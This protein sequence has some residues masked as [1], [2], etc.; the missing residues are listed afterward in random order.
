MFDIVAASDIYITRIGAN[1]YAGTTADYEIYYK[2]GSYVGFE[3]NASAWTKVG[4]TVSVYSFTNN[5]E[6][7]IPIDIN[8]FVAAGEHYA[9]YVTNT[10]SGGLNYTVSATGNVTL[11]TN[12]D[13]TMTGGV[14]KAY[15]FSST[16]SYR[17]FNGTI[18]YTKGSFISQ[19]SGLGSGA[20]FPVGVT[21]ESY[22]ASDGL[23]NTTNCSFTVTVKGLP[24]LTTSA[25]SSI[26]FSSATLGGN[27]SGDCGG[28]VTERGIV[29]STSDA[30]PTI[31]EGATK[32]IIGSGTGNFSQ[33]V[34]SLTPGTLYYVNAYAINSAGTSYGTTTSFTTS[35]ATPPD[36]DF[37]SYSDL[38][39]GSS[40]T[41]DCVTYG[42]SDCSVGIGNISSQAIT[43]S[44]AF[45]GSA[46]V[47][48]GNSA[49]GYG[50]FYSTNGYNFKLVS[51]AAEFFG[52]SNGN[53]TE[54]Y[55]VVGYRD[56]TEVVRANNLS[57]IAT[58]TAGSGTATITWTRED[59][60][61]DGSN[62]GV[63]S[64]G[65]GWQN[66]DKIRF[67]V[68]ES[69]DYYL[70][71]GLDNI[72]FEEAV[73]ASIPT[74]TTASV[75]TFDA[76]S[77]TMGGEVTSD[78]GA[79][80]TERGVVYSTTDNT[81]EI[82]EPGVI[83]DDNGT[84]IGIFGESVSGLSPNTTYHV[85]AYAIN[86]AG[87]SYGT[88]SSFTTF[89]V[90]E[91]NIQGNNTSIT[92]G[93]TS[94]SADDHTD[95]GTTPVCSTTIVRTFTIQNTGTGSLTIS[96]VNITGTHKDDFALTTSPAGTVEASGTTTFTITFNPSAA[97]IRIAT[98]TVNNNDANEGA[99][100]F[101]IQGA[102]TELTIGS[103]SQT[104][105]SC[106]GGSNGA[107]SVNTASGG[108]GGYTYNWTPGDPTG[109]GT[110]SVTGLTAGTWTC[111]VTDA[112]SCTTSVNFTITEPTALSLT[113]ALQTNVACNGGS[114]GAASVNAA[115]GGAGGYT[116][117]W[118]PGN[119]TGDGTTSVTGLTAGTWTCTVTDANSCT[120]SVNFTITEPT[121]LSLT[122]ASQTNVACNGGSN[123]AASV[124]TA[125][126]GAG[127]YTY[128]WTPGDPT[129][130][131]TTSVTGLTAGTWTCTVT[132]ANSCTTSV[133]FTITEPT[134]L[135][136]T[137]ASQTNIACNGGSNGAAS[138]NTASG[139]AGGY[140]YNWTPGNPTGDGTTSVTGL[141]AGTW[142]CTVTDANSCTTSVNFTITEPTALSLTAASQ[143]NVACNG[144]SNGAATVNAATG[145]A[146][147]YTYN[148]SPSGGTGL[149]ATG[150]TAGN[151]TCTVTDAN[152]CTTSV[153]F[154]ITQPTAL[155][156]T[157]ASQT[158]V[159]VSGGTDGAASV[160]AATGGTAPYM[161]DWTGSP[162][163]DGTRSVT[164]LS[165]GTWTC[166][167]TDANGCT[168]SWN[169]TIIE[170]P[171]LTT[172]VAASV[173]TT[174]ATLGGN[175]T[176][177]GGDAV[178]ARG[179]VY[180]TTDATP[181]IDESGVTQD[182]NGSG[183]GSF[184]ESIGS[185][186]LATRYYY[187][188]YATNAV[189]TSYGGVQEFTTQNT[190]ASIVRSGSN[191]VNAASVS[192]TV[193]FSASVTGLSSSNF[194]LANTG[195][196]SPLIT[197][198]SGSG[199][200][201]TVTVNTGTGSGTLGLNLTGNTG[202]NASLSNIPFTGE[203]Y[204]IDKT[205]STL[206]SSVP[207][208]NAANVFL[209]QDIVLTFDDNMVK[210]TGNITIKNSDNSI[211][212]QI[213]VTDSKITVSG[214]Q[215]TINP[216]ATFA[217]GTGYYLEINA[218]ALKDDAE[219]PFAGISD[220]TTLNF[221]TVD[222]V[223]NEL[224]SHPL[225]RDFQHSINKYNAVIFLITGHGQP[226][227]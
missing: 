142:T 214:T 141:T 48:L 201:W 88:A 176:A 30:T 47:I 169:F 191:P 159:S 43:A 226:N 80:V 166:T 217:R 45:S 163:G 186:A 89:G 42:G 102:G 147:G 63:L 133:N 195:L 129:G 23:G 116:Y 173:A 219:N 70:Y 208:D 2:S 149:T 82:G 57:V 211:F 26:D 51:L 213:D 223:I 28:A 20:S 44:P 183:T 103:S 15:P 192:W 224:V 74:I 27:I 212:E 121:A 185:L 168:A 32:V 140:T 221:T 84:G 200:T 158:N 59:F 22:T 146:G 40:A 85:R 53:C 181:T 210:G 137:A 49:G 148:W 128:N 16:Y 152:Y 95:F 113:A 109:D 52:H 145:G 119:P 107:A 156:L 19:I 92:S 174:S 58:G 61:T 4:N 65:T 177:D 76:T 9:F 150:L 1:L 5:V 182:T 135:S 204:T 64:F 106:N 34:G 73:S 105:V 189:G 165:A 69:P 50:E 13:L 202:L 164:G 220:A 31:G 155:N 24:V 71:I 170:P 46:A 205:P 134:A 25:A 136:L 180:S 179:V 62:S 112:N 93:D 66:I 209:G 194:A 56:D 196:T 167:V 90:T 114:N 120:T 203:V 117:N 8:L 130:D 17:L 111:T 216:D 198:V 37:G 104:N 81:P 7:E 161:Y 101:A 55:N 193:T 132:D 21:T 131:G 125:S 197:N 86:S 39:Y 118:T 206:S 75:S 124:N 97:G 38:A 41:Y 123:G 110:T 10:V 157:A 190:V 68:V 126:G 127:G 143:T 162:T 108:A 175:I 96:S 227:W 187:Q 199:T 14:G 11:A 160:N 98:I 172:A 54:I 36:Q 91:I 60:D 225:K 18:H 72:N 144:G 87:T 6:T 78:G 94:P 115:S 35:C 218:T 33:S 100:D 154:T 79:D 188:A 3:T 77:A 184:T 122:A 153:S 83:K 151:Y 99:Y 171:T 138:V 12:G 139:G 222:V 215:V 29:Y 207:A 67:E 178:S